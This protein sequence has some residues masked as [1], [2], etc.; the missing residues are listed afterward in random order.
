MQIISVEILK[1]NSLQLLKELEGLKIIRLIKGKR[2]TES[3][4]KK[5]KGFFLS[6]GIWENRDITTESLRKEAWKRK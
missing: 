2:K 4:P 1:P 6:A 3:K 5:E